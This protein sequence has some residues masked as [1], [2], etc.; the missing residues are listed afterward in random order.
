[1]GRERTVAYGRLADLAE[2]E[3]RQ[4]WVKIDRS[5]ECIQVGTVCGDEQNE[6]CLSA[7]HLL[8][9]RL[10]HSGMRL[11]ILGS[12]FRMRAGEKD[13]H[14]LGE[15]HRLQVF[16]GWPFPAD[17]PQVE[18]NVS[19]SKPVDTQGLYAAQRHDELVAA[20]L[21]ETENGGVFSHRYGSKVAVVKRECLRVHSTDQPP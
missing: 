19:L 10:K 18:Y 17:H 14:H 13:F 7:A 21:F 9:F 3:R 6:C 15:L 16:A 11:V 8:Q 20:H 5:A 1:M 2:G 12:R 4:G